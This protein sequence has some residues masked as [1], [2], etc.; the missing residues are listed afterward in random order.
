MVKGLLVWTLCAVWAG[1]AVAQTYTAEQHLDMR[2]TGVL[3][4][5]DT[6]KRDDLVTVDISV[7]STPMLL[8]LGKVEELSTRE[9]SQVVKH[10]VLLK[11]VRFT[12]SEELMAHLLNPETIG[13][14]LTIEGWLNAQTRL[15]QVTAVSEGAKAASTLK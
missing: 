12:G 13:K 10:D 11:K 2:I 1:I 5:L 4:A 8:R 9:K 7:Q 14:V 15:F 6:P 3:L